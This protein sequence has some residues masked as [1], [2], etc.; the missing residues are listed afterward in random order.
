VRHSAI[1]ARDRFRETP[2]GKTEKRR[3]RR[4]GIKKRE[5]GK[6]RLPYGAS[7]ILLYFT[8]LPLF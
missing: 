7:V 8:P 1:H 6:E 3:E 4:E 2:A 5:T